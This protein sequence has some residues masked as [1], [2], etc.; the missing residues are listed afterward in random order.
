MKQII[1]FILAC[2]ALVIVSCKEEVD[3]SSRYVFKDET[4]I[5][6]LEKHGQ[7][8]EYLELL[9]KVNVSRRS[10]TTVRQLL[11][12]R[13]N[14]TVFAPTNDAI[15]KYL[16]H[17][18]E[19]EVIPTP[20]WDAFTDK[21]IRDSIEQ[22]IV[23]NSVIDGGDATQYEVTAMPIKKGGTE[24]PLPTMSDRKVVVE[25][26]DTDPDLV[27]I[28]DAPIN[29]TERDILTINGVIHAMDAVVVSTNNTLGDVFNRIVREKKEGY[30]VTALLA[31]E[32]GLFDTLSKFRDERYE[33]LFLEEKLPT[34]CESSEGNSSQVFYTPEHRYYGYTLFAEPD[35]KWAEWL[36][37][38]ATD[39]TVEDVVDYLVGSGIYPEAKNNGNHKDPEDILNL[40][41][42]YH[43]LPMKLMPERLVYHYNEKGYDFKQTKNPAV[44]IQEFYTTMG[45][46]RLIKLFESKQSNGI[47][48]NR[49]PNLDNGR[50]G[51]YHELSCDEDK[52]GVAVGKHDLTGDM[53]IRN[54]II[55]PIDKLLVYDTNTRQNLQRQRIRWNVTAMW[56]EFMN[57]DIRSSDKTDNQHN[58][59][60]I[61]SDDI[62]KYLDDVEINEGTD[63]CY[64]TGRTQG[65]QNMHGDEMTIRGLFEVVMRLPPVPMRGTYELRYAIQSGGNMRGI[66]QFYWGYDLSKLAS[67]GIPIDMRQGGDNMLHTQS[68]NKPSK[69]GFVDDVDDDDYN[70]ENDKR[71]RNNGFMK[72]CNQYCAGAPLSAKTM[73]ESNICIRRIILRQTMDPDKTYYIK[74]KTVM[75]D[76]TRFFYMD[77]LEYCA[78]EVYDNPETPEDIW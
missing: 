36:G 31:Q 66:T 11:T 2:V 71:L 54:A 69:I 78:K 29:V 4:I 27:T 20:E 23:Y 40:F 43:Y 76:P 33:T 30:Y 24:I 62:Y 44:A 55:Y 18:V 5:S 32:V 48:I 42:T 51:T 74:F 73:R 1:G 58:S 10:K 6:Y 38:P 77:Y 65:W 52:V 34:K 45:K 26:S 7:Y 67:M 46:R 47:Y 15:A 70:A 60:Y 72:G 41:V 57:N 64:W 3:T 50:H 49:F 39:I 37:K 28:N 61:P 63:F 8:S 68:G 22:L 12:A 75:D 35:E 13:G 56:P 17:L 19:D 25:F 16:E 59:V 9:G 14:Y 21:H 53:N